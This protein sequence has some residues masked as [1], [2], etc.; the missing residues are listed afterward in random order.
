VLPAFGLSAQYHE[1][2]DKEADSRSDEK[3]SRRLVPHVLDD[4]LRELFDSTIDSTPPMEIL[5]DEVAWKALE[6][7]RP[8]L[9]TIKRWFQRWPTANIGIVTGAVSGMTVLD[10]GVK[11]GKR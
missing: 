5:P 11:P 8:M 3:S 9:D 4:I 6:T 7:T 2:A 1:H 10:V